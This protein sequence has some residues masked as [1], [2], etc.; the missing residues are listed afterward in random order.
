MYPNFLD[1]DQKG[2]KK[3]YTNDGIH[4]TS[5]AYMVWEK[6]LQKEFSK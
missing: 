4:L 3:T 2:L 1:K 6:I 5:K